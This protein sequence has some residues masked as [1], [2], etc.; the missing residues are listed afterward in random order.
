L[1]AV[2]SAPRTCGGCGLCCKLFEVAEL[3]KPRDTWCRHVLLGKG[4]GLHPNWPK[5]CNDFLCLW[6]DER[7]KPM[8]PD[9]VRPDRCGVV[10]TAADGGKAIV[11]VCQPD[12]PF[13][14]RDNAQ[15]FVFL[16]IMAGT[17]ASVSVRSG[18]VYF[19]VGSRGF[20]EVPTEWIDKSGPNQE[21]KVA[22]PN[23]LRM[24]LGIGPDAHKARLD[25]G[26]L[27]Q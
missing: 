17:G 11:A 3:V 12:K 16:T 24:K 19:I 22:V 15:V 27:L 6:R 14:W 20:M 18:N 23:E 1:V 26:Q 25:T 10:L 5:I 2:T 9:K 8:L 4:C 13:A 21:F 7:L